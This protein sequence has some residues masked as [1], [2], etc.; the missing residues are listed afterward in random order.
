MF[1]RRSGAQTL[2]LVHK[3]AAPVWIARATPPPPSL[4][5]DA[6][7]KW[8]GCRCCCAWRG[9]F[10]EGE[11]WHCGHEAEPMLRLRLPGAAKAQQQQQHQSSEIQCTVRLLDNSELICFIQR[12]AKG[13]FL[14]DHV[15]NHLDLLE[16]D[17]FGIRFVDPDKQRHWLDPKKSIVR[18]M[19]CQPPFTMCFRVKFYPQEPSKVREEITRYQL[20]L[21]I[22]RDVVHG[23]LLCPTSEAAWLGAC[24]L[25][26]ELGDYNPLDH[27]DGYVSAMQL[28][29]RLSQKLEARVAE[30]HRHELRGQTP[31]V[32]EIN[33]LIRAQGL[34][35]YTVDPHPCKDPSGATVFL[36][37]TPAGFVGFQGNKRVQLLKWMDVGKLKYEGKSFYIHGVQN[38]KK[39]VLTY[40]AP[41]PSACK[42]LWKCGVENQAFYK[43]EK[44]CEIKTVLSSNLF[45]RGSRFRYRVAKEVIEAS[46]RIQRKSPEVQ[47]SIGKSRSSLSFSQQSVSTCTTQHAPSEFADCSFLQ[48]LS[49]LKA[50]AHS[51]PMPGSSS[52][53]DPRCAV[54]VGSRLGPALSGQSRAITWSGSGC[55]RHPRSQSRA[56]VWPGGCLGL[57]ED[58]EDAGGGE[59]PLI[60][61]DLTYSPTSSTMPTPVE[62]TVTIDSIFACNNKYREPDTES[63]CEG[64]D[65]EPTSL[66][67]MTDDDD[68][69]D[70]EDGVGDD[71]EE[72]AGWQGDRLELLGTRL[73]GG[74]ARR[75]A[76]C[77]CGT[78]RLLL[79]LAASLGLLL[80]L[81]EAGLD[82]A[83]LR[84]IR[85]TPEFQ[86]LHR[87]YL[88]PL[89]RW[90]STRLQP[91]SPEVDY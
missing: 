11:I 7:V 32:A 78:A 1:A 58:R 25:Q 20:Y 3:E 16:R 91:S 77:A 22:K 81:L 72:D 41:T 75:G 63:T 62:D 6:P 47:R 54:D 69:D 21:Q 14:M 73:L 27:H 71:S 42:H 19:K 56:E 76:A 85:Q 70:D 9:R 53:Q 83:P 49:A 26:A 43:F 45:F 48:G 18:Q 39:T 33:F 86:Q 40:H 67:V 23:R 59:Q 4:G 10:N 15:C 80:L 84:E 30:I 17:Y 57:L 68:D 29:P 55:G 46:A 66:L 65:F 82:A 51:T 74:A 34:D 60:I 2:H 88:S 44:S 5:R 61:A 52:K 35:T 89:R 36:G 8:S 12:D 87:E 31:A 50:D 38:R 24:I 13:R 64:S 79:A 37:F 28:F 90:L